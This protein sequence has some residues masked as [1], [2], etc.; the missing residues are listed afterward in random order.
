MIKKYQKFDNIKW[1]PE[2]ATMEIIKE[3]N[4]KK[5]ELGHSTSRFAF[6]FNKDKIILLK[7][8]NKKRGYDIPGGHIDE[9]ETSMEACNREVMEEVGCKIKNLSYLGY[10]LIKKDKP[11]PKYPHLISNQ[12]FFVAELDKKLD[13]KLEDDSQGM[14]ELPIKEYRRYII[15]NEKFEILN[16]FDMAVEQH[17]RRILNNQNNIQMNW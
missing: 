4:R 5:Q 16:L 6:V 7:H 10:Q 2:N 17:N 9:G 13:V 1:L 11:E 15:K 12:T 3:K 14:I 8:T